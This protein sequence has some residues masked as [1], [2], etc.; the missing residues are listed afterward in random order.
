M[1]LQVSFVMWKVSILSVLLGLRGW[2]DLAGQKCGRS[3]PNNSNLKLLED[4]V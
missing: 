4:V 3:Y 1:H 2:V